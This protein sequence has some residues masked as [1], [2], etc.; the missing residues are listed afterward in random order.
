MAVNEVAAGEH[1]GYGARFRAG[2]DMRVGVASIGYGDG[3]PRNMADGAPVLVRGRRCQMSGRVSMDMITVDLTDCPD[4][5]VGDDVVLWG[6]GLPVEQLADAS[7]T[8]PYELVCRITRRVR[9]RGG[10]AVGSEPG[11]GLKSGV[12]SNVSD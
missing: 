2:R 6:S 5:R 8:I 12:L 9:F 4:A 11:H 1:I 10:S 7:E 3:Y